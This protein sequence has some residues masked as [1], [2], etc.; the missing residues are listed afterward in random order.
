MKELCKYTGLIIGFALISTT[1]CADHRVGPC[2]SDSDCPQ[3]Q[4]CLTSVTDHGPSC[5]PEV[6]LTDPPEA[7]DVPVSEPAREGGGFVDVGEDDDDNGEAPVAIPPVTEL[8]ASQGLSSEFVEVT[9]SQPEAS[10]ITGYALYRDDEPI[11]LLGPDA[12]SFRDNHARLTTVPLSQVNFRATRGTSPD[13]IT[14][15]WRV[16]DATRAH[17]YSIAAR[18]DSDLGPFSEPAVGWRLANVTSIHLSGDLGTIEVDAEPT[19]NAVISV[20]VPAPRGSNRFLDLSATGRLDG[21]ALNAAIGHHDGPELDFTLEFVNPAGPSGI[22][23]TVGWTGHPEVDL[24]WERNSGEESAPWVALPGATQSTWLDAT[25]S[26]NGEV[27]YYRAILNGVPSDVVSAGR[28]IFDLPGGQTAE[29]S[30]DW[31]LL[32]GVELDGEPSTMLLSREG[33]TWTSMPTSLPSVEWAQQYD[34]D[35]SRVA[36]R[37]INPAHCDDNSCYWDEYGLSVWQLDSSGVQT[38]AWGPA[39]NDDLNES[40]SLALRGSTLVATD[41]YRPAAYTF[42]ESGPG[43]WTATGALL[44]GEENKVFS[45]PITDTEMSDDGSLFAMGTPQL[46]SASPAFAVN[47]QAVEL[48]EVPAG[49]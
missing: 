12:T 31:A 26:R 22:V 21:V 35:G 20:E 3:G 33:S 34:L 9:W 39:W 25:T 4:V 8:S 19:A 23:S 14:L 27:A 10:D 42:E 44:F 28:A 36:V 18:R 6:E 11:A 40:T 7:A 48:L 1:G 5:G 46:G 17:R 24:Q 16:P 29:I 38:R 43:V 45:S 47:G 30:A 2:E 41:G 32:G 13:S 37:E 15:S 49:L